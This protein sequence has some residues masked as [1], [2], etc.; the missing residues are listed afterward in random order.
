MTDFLAVAPHQM[1][2]DVGNALLEAGASAAE[3]AVAMGACLS[4]VMPH[5]CG[6]GGDAIWLLSDEEGHVTALNGIGQAFAFTDGVTNVALRG[7][8]S[9]LTTAGAVRTWQAALALQ[10]P[11]CAVGALL[12]PAIRAANDGFAVGSSQ[13][14]WT[15]MRLADMRSWT[16][17]SA[18]AGLAQ[19]DQLVQ[20][21]LAK[22]LATLAADGLES[23][24]TGSVAERITAD[25]NDLGVG[26]TMEDLA[27]ARAQAA[28]PLRMPYRD[29]V[30]HAPP[31]PTQGATTLEIMGILDR[32]GPAPMCG[33]AADYHL[34]VEA[35]KAAF[36]DRPGIDD[37]ETARSHAEALLDPAHLDSRAASVD[38]AAARPWPHV[39][40]TADTVY[41]AARDRQGRCVSALQST[42]YDWGSGCCLPRTGIIWHNRGA[43]FG[44]AEG[45]N[46]LI[47]GRRP[48]HT[49]NPGIATR[50]GKPYLLYG[51][52]GADGQ[53]QTCCVL[54]RHLVDHGLTPEE[55]LSAPRFLLGKTFSDSRDSLK[56]EPMGAEDEMRVLGHDVSPIPALSP[57]AGLAGVVRIEGNIVTGACDPRGLL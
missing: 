6:I 42:Y 1:A 47:P 5:F 24:Y 55:A 28:E 39:Y 50:G 4:V 16:G 11:C 56:L 2:S 20:S 34:M 44:L 49:L 37:A 41:F 15:Q 12:E 19:G 17:F 21:S 35:V 51:T 26:A 33:T 22:T 18:Y 54:L 9:I 46:K 36:L 7:Q 13:A 48:F 38:A 10:A 32:L 40:Q 14:F 23:F 30:L 52:Q 27:S 25:L 43:S 3:A 45:P 29:V 53:P 8:G 57:L 31:P